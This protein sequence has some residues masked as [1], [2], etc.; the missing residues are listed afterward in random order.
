MQRENLQAG[1][2]ETGALTPTLPPGKMSC[3]SCLQDKC[4]GLAWTRAGHSVVSDETL[5]R[6][7]VGLILQTNE[8]LR[9]N[10]LRVPSS[11]NM[12]IFKSF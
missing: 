8:R 7:L 6:L 4:P 2:E 5:C 12:L 1:R 9:V 3:P 11:L 10:G